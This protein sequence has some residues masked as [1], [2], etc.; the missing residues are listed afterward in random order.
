MY[1]YAYCIC[2]L[3]M[4]HYICT[5]Y[6]YA[7]YIYTYTLYIY[8]IYVYYITLLYFL[9]DYND[10]AATSLELLRGNYPQMAECFK[11]VNDDQVQAP[12][13]EGSYIRFQM[14]RVIT[15]H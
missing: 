10:L 15:I 9:I 3:C 4:A 11:L 14:K 2:T 1:I 13:K 8:I 7:H 6:I 5:L 12:K